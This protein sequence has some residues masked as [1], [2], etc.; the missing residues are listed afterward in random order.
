M[1]TASGAAFALKDHLAMLVV[2]T[3]LLGSGVVA[4]LPRG[5][6][7][8]VVTTAITFATM[9]F[10]ILLLWEVQ[11]RGVI[12]YAI[13]GWQPPIGIEYRVDILNAFVLAIVATMGAVTMPFALRSVPSDVN[14]ASQPWFYAIYLLCLT[15]LLGMAVSGDAFN[16]FVFMEISSLATY[17]LIAMGRD[18]RALLAAYQYLIMGTIGATF[19]VLG[20]GLLYIVTGTLNL[21]DIAG[22][23][24][25]AY[26]VHPRPVMAALAF[27]IVG[28]SLKLALFPLHVW[29]PNAYTFAPPFATVFL[30]ATATKVAV[31]VL[32]R[33]YFGVFGAAIDVSA[34]PI[35]EAL[36]VLAI[37][38]MFVASILAFYE[39]RIERILAY[40]SVAQ[41]GYIILGISLA[42]EN[43]LTGGIVH[44]LNHAVSKALLF[45]AIGAVTYRLGHPYL[46]QLS[47]IG[48]K[49]P[50]TTAAFVL[51]G[52]SIIG[53]PGTAGFVSKW[54]LSM[55][56][57]DAEMPLLVFLI[58]A[59]S[60]I[61]VLYIGRIIE[62]AYF[63]PVSKDCERAT[64]PGLTMLIPIALMAAA[65]LY[66][67]IDTALSADIARDA[68]KLILTGL[69][70]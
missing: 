3:P 1:S 36:L 59:S 42:N 15:G 44:I 10:S 8:W 40:S 35:A 45:L 27:L 12:S 55:G 54:Q 25:D 67:G 16:I 39:N 61:S 24:G 22:R 63:R 26:A 69:K 23:I 68:A 51:G 49:M 65:T 17:V 28:I 21:A 33:I 4:M 19:Y 57:I 14:P 50:V 31:Y 2:V 43:G 30:A 58:V 60:I 38:A 7:S 9:A 11:E 70:S 48:R 6:A 62:V 34:L 13:G 29:L 53:V 37:V 20:V 5:A 64:D 41:I 47:G 56:A 32:L 46:E 18:K 52:L 66:F